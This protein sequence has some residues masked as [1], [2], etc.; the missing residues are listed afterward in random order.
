MALLLIDGFEGYGTL[1]ITTS[2]AI[3]YPGAGASNQSIVA[4]RTSGYGLRAYNNSFITSH[5]TTNPTLIAGAAFYLTTITSSTALAFYD[6][7]VLGV[8]ITVYSTAPSTIAI[9]VDGTTVSTV[10][11]HT[12]LLLNTW[13]Y[14]ELKVYCHSTDGTIEVRVNGTTVASLSGIN[15]KIGTDSFYNRVLFGL[16]GWSQI[17]DFYVCDGSSISNNS[18]Q[19]VC[20]VYAV[21]PNRDTDTIQWTTST[22]LLHYTLIDEN[23][24]ITTDYV[25][26]GTQAQTDLY[27][28]QTLNTTNTIKGIQISTIG[29]LASGLS[30]ILEVPI[31]SNSIVDVGDDITVSSTQFGEALRISETDPNT[32]EPWTTAGLAAVQIG[33]KIM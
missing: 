13:Y 2:V 31:S 30:T 5:L 14:I 8:K 17:D 3:R 26:S 27:Q 24:Y 4:G 9:V 33:L 32:N 1:G 7:A 22:G 10:D 29:K 15:T 18:F 6:N 23:P 16:Y 25:I 28:Y 11:L 12:T 21:Y 19:G 20:K